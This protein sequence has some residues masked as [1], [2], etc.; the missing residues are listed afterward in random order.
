MS[1]NNRPAQRL[2]RP[3]PPDDLAGLAVQSSGTGVSPVS[4][5]GTGVQ[6]VTPRPARLADA[7]A[8]LACVALL[9]GA[10]A[11]AT[12]M[13]LL[14]LRALGDVSDHAVAIEVLSRQQ[15]QIAAVLTREGLLV[16]ATDLE[17]QRVPPATESPRHLPGAS[18]AA[19]P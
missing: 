8:T 2:I 15:K 11:A 9:I 6:S 12:A 16:P 7:A 1:E 18:E 17:W 3:P 13:T 10:V 4:P 14:S 19:A 5:R